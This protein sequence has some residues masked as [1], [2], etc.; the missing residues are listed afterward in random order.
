MVI[1]INGHRPRKQQNGPAMAMNRDDGSYQLSHVYD[2]LFAA[3]A[4]KG[5]QQRHCEEG[6]S[7]CRNVNNSF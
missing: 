2:K 5:S 7:R 1:D 6:N 4:A 3:A